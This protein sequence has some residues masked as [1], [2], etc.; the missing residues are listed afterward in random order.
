MKFGT[1]FPG[2]FLITVA[3]IAFFLFGKRTPLVDLGFLSFK[4]SYII[5]L[6]L[7]SPACNSKLKSGRLKKSSSF[8]LH[9]L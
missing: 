8:K 5:K 4:L 9:Q 2:H 3:L 1:S 7:F 6:I